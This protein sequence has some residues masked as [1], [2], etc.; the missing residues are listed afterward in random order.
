MPTSII[1]I[2]IK[3]HKATEFIETAKILIGRFMKTCGCIDYRLD[4]VRGEKTVV[5]L[6]GNWTTTEDMQAHF[7]SADFKVLRGAIRV[8]GALPEFRIIDSQERVQNR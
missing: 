7:D 2:E 3:D 1:L 4:Q 5:R 6:I 8:L